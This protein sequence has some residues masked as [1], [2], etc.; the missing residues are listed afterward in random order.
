MKDFPAALLISVL[1]LPLSMALAI[2]SGCSPARGLY[3]SVVA[4]FLISLLGG[5]RHQV[6]GPTA[7]FVVVIYNVIY[8]FGYNGLA[9]ATIMAGLML[10]GAGCCRFG[11]IIKY[12]PFPITTGFTTGLGIMLFVSQFKDLLGLRIDEVPGDLINKI[13]CFIQHFYTMNWQAIALSALTVGIVLFLRKIK[14]KYP[15]FFIAFVLVTLIS[16]VFE[17]DVPTI[18]SDFGDL[19][20]TLPGIY[21]PELSWD[22]IMTLFPSAFT[23]AF[24]AGIESLLSCVIADS[25]AG[26]KHRSNCE[27]IAQGIGNIASV[28][29]GGIPAT[30]ALARTATNVRSGAATPIAGMLHSVLIFFMML[31]FAQYIKWIPLSCLASIL[32]IVAINMID[33]ER[34]KSIMSATWGDIT[35]FVVTFCLTILVDITVAIEVGCILAILFFTARMIELTESHVAKTEHSHTDIPP[36]EHGLH[37]LPNEIEMIYI[38]GPFFFGVAAKVNDVLAR[39]SETPK[40]MILDMKDVPFIDASGAFTIQNFVERAKIKGTRV[41][42]TRLNKPVKHALLKMSRKKRGIY[43]EFV[44]DQE[45]AIERAYQIKTLDPVTKSL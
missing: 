19:P 44:D 2:A 40:V 30:G 28:C 20:R 29:F 32:I 17:M 9:V 5:S 12:L 1:S 37:V 3:T 34:V 16:T 39:L 10:I 18:A 27:L 41:I 14:P 7:A 45:Q 38:A 13:Y 36:Y 35:V 21:I 24:L 22:M 25:I 26:T 4:G 43:G 23:I 33:T 6:A 15:S 8:K 31:F 11:S 42:L